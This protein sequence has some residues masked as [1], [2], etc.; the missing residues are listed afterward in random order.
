MGVVI[1]VVV[2]TVL[3]WKSLIKKFHC[4]RWARSGKVQVVSNIN[5]DVQPQTVFKFSIHTGQNSSQEL[6]GSQQ[7]GRS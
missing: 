6:E 3:V 1:K 4:N 7:V 5:T 2:N